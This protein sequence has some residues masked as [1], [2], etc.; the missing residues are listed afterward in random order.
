MSE[1][2]LND[3]LKKKYEEILCEMDLR[4]L[5]QSESKL[6][7]LFLAAAPENYSKCKNT[8]M[9]VGSET[10]DWMKGKTFATLESCI[11]ESMV[12]TRTVAKLQLV[13][14]NG[15]GNCF[16]NFYRNVAKK[17]ETN[18]LIY[19]NL[20]CFAWN[21][22]CPVGSKHFSTIKHYSKLLLKAQ[23]EILEPKVIIFANGMASVPYRREFFPISGTD[24]VCVNSKDYKDRGIKNRHLWEFTLKHNDSDI[25]A[26]R[27][28]HPSAI[29]GSKEASKARNFLIDQLLPKCFS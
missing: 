28:Q 4:L 23:I 10:R 18:G 15:R 3:I 22:K 7:G 13:E 6:S 20:F 2:N 25:R 27:V 11:E 9:L 16:Y 12:K 26:F 21:E 14:K 24:C 19:A 5:N 8:I 1:K 17:C 29:R